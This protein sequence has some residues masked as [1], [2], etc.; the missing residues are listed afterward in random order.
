MEALTEAERFCQTYPISQI[1]IDATGGGSKMI[2]KDWQKLTRLP[3][4]AAQKTHKASQISVI[5]GDLRAGKLKIAREL[6][7]KLIND[8]MILEW[9]ADKKERN[10]YEYPRGASDH[11]A[12]ALQYAYNLCWHHAHDFEY[13]LSVQPGSEAWYAREERL[14][15]EQQLR[16]MDQD[17]EGAWE[18]LE[19]TLV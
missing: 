13:D 6:N 17:G 18:L 9:D 10:K 14:M 5:N 3:L 1:A 19:S 15:E 16:E 2:L 8:L 4:E 7:Q 11:L 12:D